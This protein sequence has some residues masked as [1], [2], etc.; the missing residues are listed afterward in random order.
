VTEMGKDA[1]RC[2][3]TFEFFFVGGSWA[4]GYRCRHEWLV[5]GRGSSYASSGGQL[6]IGEGSKKQTMGEWK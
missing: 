2:K 1:I 3:V 5:S 4:E 6:P